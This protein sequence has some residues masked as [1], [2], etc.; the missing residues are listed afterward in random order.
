MIIICKL[1]LA[2]EDVALTYSLE[3]KISME[4]VHGIFTVTMLPAAAA[5]AATAAAATTA[6]AGG[7]VNHWLVY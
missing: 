1:Y 4:H 3:N 5:A 6:A 7:N 2:A